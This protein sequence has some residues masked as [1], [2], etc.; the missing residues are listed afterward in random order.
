MAAYTYLPDTMQFRCTSVV[1]YPTFERRFCS[2]AQFL[3]RQKLKERQTYTGRIT[4]GAYKRLNRAI[5]L[6]VQAADQKTVEFTSKKSGQKKKLKFS[7]NFITLTVHS[8]DRMIEGKE[9]HRLCLEP[10]ILWLKRTCGMTLYIWKAELQKR[11][12]IHYHVTTDCYVEAMQL[13]YKWNDLQKEAGYLNQY[14][15]KFGHYNA[16]STDVHSVYKYADISSYLKKN[17]CKSI[18]C[19]LAKSVQNKETIGGKVWD[20]SLNLKSC[21]LFETDFD[22]DLHEKIINSTYNF[23]EKDCFKLYE[24]DKKTSL[25]LSEQYK[26]EYEAHMRNVRNYTRQSVKKDVSSNETPPVKVTFKPQLTLFSP[27]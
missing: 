1:Q 24:T 14:F 12:Q 5:E 23:V 11:G 15:E 16:N 6:L 25:L 21:K 4:K 22:Y 2:S 19:E 10:L 13:R 7:L 3:N 8:P 9:A 27:S 18:N 17:V 20:C 26:L